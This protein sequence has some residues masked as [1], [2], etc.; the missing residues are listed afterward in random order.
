MN[1]SMIKSNEKGKMILILEKNDITK[2]KVYIS[3]YN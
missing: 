1:R 2:I 3:Q